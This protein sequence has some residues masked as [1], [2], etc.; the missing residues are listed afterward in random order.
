MTDKQG[1]ATETA[2]APD[3][4]AKAQADAQRWEDRYWAECVRRSKAEDELSDM[5]R[6]V[7]AVRDERDAL[8]H[9]NAALSSNVSR[10]EG[11]K[12]RVERVDDL[13]R[14]VPPMEGIEN[15]ADAPREFQRFRDDAG[16]LTRR[17]R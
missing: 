3:P 17:R 9:H 14:G 11:Y 16:R 4:L 13:D 6:E 8:Q 15:D 12:Q 10:L 5:R 7:R 2:A 1:D